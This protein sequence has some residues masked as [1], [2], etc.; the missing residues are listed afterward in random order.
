MRTTTDWDKYESDPNSFFTRYFFLNSVISAYSD[1][2]ADLDFE[3]P[4]EILEFGCGTGYID[5]WL[6]QKFNVKNV[7]LIDSNK[8][9]LNIAKKTLSKVQ[10]ETE[11]IEMDFFNFKTSK[12]YDIVHSQGVIEHFEPKKRYALLKKHYDS[13]KP[14]GYCIVYSPTP[15]KPY[16]FFRKLAEKSGFWKFPDEVPLDD[17]IIIEEMTSLGFIKIKS[18]VFW[19]YFL[20][21]VGIIFKKDMQKKLQ[22]HYV[23]PRLNKVLGKAYTTIR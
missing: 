15:S 20:T 21:E 10:C 17:K 8:R 5:K 3:K 13:T 18:N 22:G 6:C 7:T 4:I 12:Q 11:F 14:G 1:L 9:M 16:L 19:K 23:K 2:L